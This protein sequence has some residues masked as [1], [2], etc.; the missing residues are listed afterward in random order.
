MKV[1]ITNTNYLKYC[2]SVLLGIL[3]FYCTAQNAVIDSLLN[4]RGEIQTL[5]TSE[6][7]TID[8]LHWLYSRIDEATSSRYNDTLRIM[9]LNIGDV[10]ADPLW[11]KNR[12]DLKVNNGD[13]EKGMIL[14][15]SAS[16]LLE[17]IDENQSSKDIIRLKGSI[18]SNYGTALYS[19]GDY[20]KAIT[21]FNKILNDSSFQKYPDFVFMAHTNSF[22]SQMRLGN[23]EAGF[24][25]LLKSAKTA[26]IHGLKQ[27]EAIASINICGN[28]DPEIPREIAYKYCINT[29]ELLNNFRPSA[30]GTAY[31]HYAAH[32]QDN[33]VLDSALYYYEKSLTTEYNKNNTKH[34]S[35]FGIS[36]I[37]CLQSKYSLCKQYADSAMAIIEKIEVS[38]DIEDHQY[39][40][41]ILR[42]QALLGMGDASGAIEILEPWTNKSLDTIGDY[43]FK[44]SHLS[45]L[46]SALTQ[47]KK[48]VPRELFARYIIV[49]DTMKAQEMRLKSTK[50]LKGLAGTKDSL[51]LAILTIESKEQESKLKKRSSAMLFLA[52]GMVLF[53]SLLY[54]FVLLSYRLRTKKQ[55]LENLNGEISTL[56]RELN[57]RTA[58]QISLAYEL[59]LDQRRQIGDEQ[60][61]ASLERSESQLM[62]LREV[63]R[64]L[65]HRSDDLVRAD[66]VL[67]KVAE[68][69][70][71]ASPHPFNLDLQLKAITV[72]GN[73]ASR[74][75]LI[76]SELLSNSIKYAFPNTN[77][78]QAT[79]R[80]SQNEQGTEIS[81]LD[82][83]PGSDGTVQGTG[84]GSG[85]IEAMLEDLDAEFE[86]IKDQDGKGY[87]LRWYWAA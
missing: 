31:N 7:S 24:E 1:R 46:I 26:K 85:L 53:A 54:R 6:F 14:Y 64:A 81:Y 3:S 25:S 70:Q 13:I 22:A 79:I 33:G 58:N 69:L 80:I 61:K 73:A 49:R 18:Y 9:L 36:Q 45:H 2:S 82:N 59:I 16:A 34:F 43:E 10:A 51:E 44:S 84:V 23:I 57:H 76:L 21:R 65:A 48:I 72:H 20:E 62:A 15:D 42:G 12:A 55:D 17:G 71:A 50:L 74:S 38:G 67:T 19:K 39:S 11:L 87:G 35:Y 60:A 56:N 30:I 86:E 83:G 32:L 41:N 47:A 63:N 40:T 78:P 5:D 8:D 52:L 29:K 77:A 4:R 68:G 75:A 28:L 66:E 37:Y 27:Y